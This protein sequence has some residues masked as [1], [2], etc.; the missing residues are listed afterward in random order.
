MFCLKCGTQIPD[1]SEFCFKCGSASLSANKKGFGIGKAV[2][3]RST[4]GNIGLTAG[5]IG[6]KK[7]LLLA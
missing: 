7:Y 4:I 2:I 1:K 6:A 3:G 5:N